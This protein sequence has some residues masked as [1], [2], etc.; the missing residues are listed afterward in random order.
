MNDRPP[1]LETPDRGPGI[2]DAAWI[3]RRKPRIPPRVVLCFFHDVLSARAARGDLVEIARLRGEGQPMP[4]YRLG[5]GDAALGVAF[6]GLTAPL[7]AAV[8]EE[9]IGL[10]GQGFVAC[11]GAG[12]LDGAIP[13]GQVIVPTRALRA[14]G[15]S[16]HYL[17]P[18]RFVRPHPAAVRAILD[19]CR[20]RG[21]KPLRGAVWTTDGVYRETPALIRKRRAEGCL[22]VEMEAAAFFAVAQFR[23]VVFGQL[24]YAGDDVSGARWQHRQW[25]QLG[26]T[27]EGLL[28]LAL[29]AARRLPIAPTPS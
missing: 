25:L 9:L 18:A 17:R 5:E 3:L 20:A 29:D 16:Y 26:E 15:T 11:G 12:V 1:I 22:A 28:D 8:L 21:V 6:P 10:G 19:A 23:K 24:L 14:E 27:R 7:C 2:I 4:V 13:A